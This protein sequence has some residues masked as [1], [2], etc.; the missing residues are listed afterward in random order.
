MT[1]HLQA[2]GDGDDPLVVLPSFG[3]DNSSMAAAIEPAFAE[4]SGWRRLYIDL[5]GNGESS[6]HYPPRSDAVLDA[7]VATMQAELHYRPFAILG[8]SYGGYL[9]AGVTRRLPDQVGGLMPV[10]TGFKIRPWD[11]DLSGVLASNPHPGWL[12]HVPSHLRG[13]FSHAVGL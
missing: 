4:A 13:H 7:V 3:F 1:L 2:H 11:R 5:Q 9:A 10:C 6:V 8:W 12:D